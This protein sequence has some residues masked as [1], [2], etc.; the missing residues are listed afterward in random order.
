MEQKPEKTLIQTL[1]K[2]WSR[3]CSYAWHRVEMVVKFP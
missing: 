3:P 2:C 1:F